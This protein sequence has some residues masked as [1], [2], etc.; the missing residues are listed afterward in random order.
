MPRMRTVAAAVAALTTLAVPASAAGLTPNRE[1]RATDDEGDQRGS[2]AARTA[3]LPAHPPRSP[4]SAERYSQLPDGERRLHPSELGLGQQP[5]QA[6]RRG[7]RVALAGAG[8]TC[9]ARMRRWLGVAVAPRIVLSPTMRR[10]GAGVTRGRFGGRDAPRSGCCTPAR[11][12]L[13]GTQLPRHP[14][15][16]ARRGAH[17]E[18]VPAR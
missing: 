15:S 18:A 16:V 11:L 13:P 7:A 4:A 9:A 14:A 6:D 5:L 1:G 12:T 10:H 8:S 17:G 2:S 3:R